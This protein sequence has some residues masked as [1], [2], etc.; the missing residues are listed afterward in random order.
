MYTRTVIRGF[1]WSLCIWWKQ[2]EEKSHL[3][4][5]KYSSFA[6]IVPLTV[7]TGPFWKPVLH[8]GAAVA[9]AEILQARGPT[10]ASDVRGLTAIFLLTFP[11]GS[12]FLPPSHQGERKSQE[13]LCSRVPSVDVMRRVPPTRGLM[14]LICF[15]RPNIPQR[16]N[17]WN[18]W[19]LCCS[20]WEGLFHCSGFFTSV[21]LCFGSLQNPPDK[22]PF[23]F[24]CLHKRRGTKSQCLPQLRMY[25][26]LNSASTCAENW[27]FANP[28]LAGARRN[29]L[30]FWHFLAIL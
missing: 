17:C 12:F 1:I 14:S 28:H 24:F 15:S 6:V 5:K 20:C 8:L 13:F 21:L 26:C 22:T 9:I 25:L 23:C 10:S 29:L 27:V 11:L 16:K 4:K 18:G 19:G 3:K 2:C 30:T 7:L